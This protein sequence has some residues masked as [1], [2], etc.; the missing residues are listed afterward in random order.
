MKTDIANLILTIRGQKV[1]LDADLAKIYG[2]TTKRLNEQVKRN[3]TRFPDDF[4]ICLTKEEKDEVVANCDHL[5]H[6]KFFKT[7]PFAFLESGCLMA[8]NLLKSSQAISMSVYV[9]RVFVKMRETLSLNQNLLKRL[10]KIDKTLLLHD[11]AL[12]DLYQKIL[13][14]LETPENSKKKI[15]FHP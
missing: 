5:A 2:V 11:K 15:G 4:I 13:P 12:Y 1:I 8:S 7:L 3:K 10:S 9:V 14:L 6:L